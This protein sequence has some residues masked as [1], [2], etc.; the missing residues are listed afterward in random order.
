MN[1]LRKLGGIAGVEKMFNTDRNAGLDLM[2]EGD[3]RR[4]VELYGD[5]LPIVKPPKTFVELV[6]EC[7]AD[8]I[9]RLLCAAAAVSLVL[10]CI[11]HGIE[12]G[13]LE[14]ASILIAVVIIVSVTS[15]NNYLKEKQFRKL[16]EIATRKFCDVIRKGK[17]ERVDVT[18][19]LAGDICEIETGEIMSVDGILLRGN[20]I[21][22]DESSITGETDLLKKH[23]LDT[24]GKCNPFLISGSRIMEGTGRIMVA[25]VGRNSQYGMLKLKIQQDPDETPLQQKL[26]LLADQIG[27]I[28][29]YSA[30]FTFL[31]MLLHFVYDCVASGQ[32]LSSFLTGETAEELVEYFI[33]AV[34]IVVVAVPEGLPLAVTIALAYSVG[35]MKDENNLVRYLQACETM[36]GADNVCTDKTGTLTKNLMTVVRLFVQLAEKEVNKD[37]RSNSI[38]EHLLELLCHG[39]IINSNANPKVTSAGF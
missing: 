7:F 19:L 33:I 27:D 18:T 10:G 38:P 35:K 28:G 23:S 39:V 22:A 17:L 24:E 14:G 34:S 30:A 37:L 12:E 20:S 16:N 2:N 31:A 32:P 25:G 29:K 5:N 21:T 4:R 9:L 8:E 3:V 1:R 13:W 26:A 6:V 15:V 36:G 11:T